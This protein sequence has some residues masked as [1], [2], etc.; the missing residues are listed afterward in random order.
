MLGTHVI[1][2]VNQKVL[3][4]LARYS[5][6][7]F[8]ER[9]IAR[10][11]PIAYGSANRSLNKLYSTGAIKRRRAGKMYFYSIDASNA[12][13]TEYKKLVNIMLIEPLVEELKK[14]A[15]RVILYGSCAQ[16]TDTSLSDFDL[17]I[18]SSNKEKIVNVIASF[19]LPR[20][21]EEL[22]IQP[23]IK[24]SIELLEVGESERAFLEEVERGIVLWERT[25]I[26]SR[27]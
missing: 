6:K 26:E 4:L 13:I 27:V 5:D 2:T 17:F 14:T 25:A 1:A 22:I 9:E 3:S 19:R 12:A 11:L 10:Q 8:Y 23:V 16:G 20:G 24:T 15:N 7:E 21:F 18:V